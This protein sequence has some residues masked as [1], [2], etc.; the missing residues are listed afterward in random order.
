MGSEDE[1]LSLSGAIFGTQQLVLREMAG[2]AAYE[3]ALASL[4]AA[5]EERVRTHAAI[6]WVPFEIVEAVVTAVAGEMDLAVEGL[7]RELVGGV[8]RH[9]VRGVWRLLVRFST[10]EAILARVGTLWSK[11]Y[12]RGTAALESFDP[13]RAGQLVV[14]ELPDASDFM[15][16]GVALGVE[17]LVGSTRGRGARVH[18]RRTPGGAVYSLTIR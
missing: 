13:G 18:W 7:Q 1:P 2:D 15:L 5:V 9:T 10:P 17:S 6:G 14:H 16:R 3:R 8:T 4:P 11:T 12:N